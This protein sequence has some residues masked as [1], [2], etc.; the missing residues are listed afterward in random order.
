MAVPVANCTCK[1]ICKWEQR[2]EET[3]NDDDYEEEGNDRAA[4]IQAM[5]VIG[6]DICNPKT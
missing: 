5:Q 2:S 4:V 1:N 3:E 6:K